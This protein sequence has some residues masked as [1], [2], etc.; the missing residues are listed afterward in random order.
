MERAKSIILKDP[1][2]ENQGFFCA[3]YAIQFKLNNKISFDTSKIN[4]NI[5]YQYYN[6]H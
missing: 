6:Q 5:D 1:D 3:I 4:C 2:L